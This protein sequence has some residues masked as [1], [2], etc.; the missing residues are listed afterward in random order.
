[1]KRILGLDLGTT[2][3]GWAYVKEAE[4]SQEQSEIIR[5]GVRVNPL[6]TDEKSNFEEGKSITTTAD[7][8]L[9]RHARR[10][11]D[12][13]QLRRDALKL[14]F[15]KEGWT[16]VNSRLYENG[17]SD[18]HETYA[19]RAKG[20]D[21]KLSLEEFARVLMMINKKRGYKSSRKATNE[22]EGGEL[23]DEMDIALHLED[24][25]ITPGQYASQ[26]LSGGKKK[27]PSF[28]KSDLEAEF[29]TIW[30]VHSKTYPDYLSDDF[31]SQI[32]GKSKTVTTKIFLA[33][34]QIYTAKHTAKNKKAEAYEW[35]AA[36]ATEVK[37]I[38]VLA[39]VLAEVNGN[40]YNSSGYLGA[41]SD[42]SKVLITKKL[43]VGQYQYQQLL[44]N[45][46]NSLRNQIFYRKDYVDEFETLW[47]TQAKYHKLSDNL[48]KEIRDRIIF[49]QRPLK[50][51]K[52]LIS[53]CEF[54]SKVVEIDSDGKKKKKTIGSRVAPRSSP[55][56]QEFKIWQQLANVQLKTDQNEVLLLSSSDKRKIF[57]LLC[58]NESMTGTEVLNHLFGDESNTYEINYAKL[59]GNKTNSALLSAYC[60][61]VELATNDKKF[62]KL[63]RTEKKNKVRNFFKQEG[64][65]DDILDFDSSLK[66]HALVRQPSYQLWHLLYSYEGDNTRS[67]VDSLYNALKTKF[68]FE[69]AFATFLINVALIQDYGQLSTKAIR[70]LLPFIKE[71]IYSDACDKAGYN[72]SNSLSKEENDKR[73]LL[74]ELEILP[75]N[76]LR[77]PVV[78]KILNQMIHVVNAVIASPAMGPPDEIRIELARELKQNAKERDKTTRAIADATKKHERIVKILQSEFDLKNPTRNDI[79]KYKLYEELSHNGYHTLY[80]NTYIKPHEL[81]SRNVDIEHIIPKALNF[82]DSFSNKTLAIRKVNAD[83]DKMTAIDFMTNT[84][85]EKEVEAYRQRVQAAYDGNHIKKAKYEKLLRPQT[86]LKNGFIQRDLRETQYIA[87]KA[88]QI[89]TA[90]TRDVLATSGKVTDRL[91]DDWNL[92]NVMKELNLPKYEA[93]GLTYKEE[94]KNNQFVTKI[95]DWTK[96]NDHRHH[97]MDALAIAFTTRSHIQYLNNLNAKSDKSGSIYGIEKKITIIDSKGKRRFLSPLENFRE[98]AKKHLKAILVSRKAKNKVVTKNINKTKSKGK[99]HKQT[100][101]TPRGQLHEETIYGS[102]FIYFTNQEKIS[103]KFNRQKI[104][105]VANQLWKEAMI[106]R[107]N[108]FNNDPKLAFTGKNSLVKYPIKTNTGKSVPPIVK[109]VTLKQRFTKRVDIQNFFTDSQRSNGAKKKAIES[110][111][112]RKIRNFLNNRLLAYENNFKLAFSNLE[113]NPIW[114]NKRRGIRLRRVTIQGVSNAL[115]IHL[116]HDHKGE[117]LTGLEGKSIPSNF[118]STGNNHHVAIYQDSNGKLQEVVVSFLE[119]VTRGNL[120]QPIINRTFYSE[121]GWKYLL[122]MKQNEYFIFPSLEF[123]PS[124]ID[125]LNPENSEVISPN[126]FRVQSLSCLKYGNSIIRDY[127]FRHHLDTS[128]TK[129]LLLKDLTYKPIKSLEPLSDIIKVRLNH[130]GEIVAVGDY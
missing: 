121:N 130:I 114:V 104:E 54:E 80:T 127:V 61:M 22:D 29:D 13:Y 75:K 105:T 3:I 60:Q 30:G 39:F 71:D 57:E 12:R 56:F 108:E 65:S 88:A 109:T 26:L 46:H 92:I 81:Y 101:L 72:H 125:L 59:D 4:N 117:V 107:L 96:R 20:V 16:T 122:N 113:H 74:K 2:S 76:A 48:K 40:I 10:N 35:R 79:I 70:K 11:L 97:A 87:R 110:I 52:G 51:Q 27:L 42:R 44:A 7:R 91:R 19:L 53:F 129:N 43:T 1:M 66:S 6:T 73:V 98:E 99:I 78:E 118:I 15:Q 50:S 33:K 128:T 116:K 126:L 82:D 119:A 68:G 106:K 45:K 14:L 100:T 112:D 21:E 36:A 28:Y 5:L 18:L 67:G 34:Y 25:K 8:T 38:D 55:L 90:V 115:P 23:I 69:R 9:K 24:N 84:R 63:C 31:Y 32:K 93:L 17:T 83:K 89:L 124:E 62:G 77:N 94:R 123:D 86:E 58:V 64:I 102:S 49:F 47:K 120:K 111:N 103:A 41:I 85:E 37:D 95:K